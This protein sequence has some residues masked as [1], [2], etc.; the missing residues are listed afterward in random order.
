MGLGHMTRTRCDLRTGAYVGLRVKNMLLTYVTL[1]F[2]RPFAVASEYAAKAGSVT[3]YVKGRIDQLEGELVR[4]QGAFGDAAA[5][6]L[7]LDFIG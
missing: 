7:G 1:G 6:A 3:F 4:Q 5:D 2:Y